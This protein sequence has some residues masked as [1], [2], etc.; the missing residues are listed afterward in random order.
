M[1]RRLGDVLAQRASETFVGRTDEL[2]E[3]LTILDDDRPIVTCLHGIGGIGKSSLLDAFKLRA[4]DAGA[5]VI[6]LDGRVIEP[7]PRGFLQELGMA[8][9]LDA[10][11]PALAVDRLESLGQR[12]VLT[13]DTYELL[14]LIDTWLRQDFLPLLPEN[15]RIVISGREPPV[16][17]WL[18]SP[19]WQDMFHSIRLGSLSEEDAI[20]LLQQRGIDDVSALRINRFADGHPLALQLAAANVHEP[21]RLDFADVAVQRVVEELARTYLA[22]VPDPL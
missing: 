6:S 20:T 13:I 7:T 8:I 16:S 15:V 4:R 3:L 1:A 5:T 18:S 22:D 14:R 12:V 9:G 19:G 10:T 2:A 17:A 21:S 11:T